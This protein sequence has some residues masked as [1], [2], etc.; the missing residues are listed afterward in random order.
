MASWL[1][2][3][4]GS[5][6]DCDPFEPRPSISMKEI[7]L[8]A[9]MVY[10]F[11]QTLFTDRGNPTPIPPKMRPLLGIRM[12][13]RAHL[14]TCR[15]GCSKHN[16]RLNARLHSLWTRQVGCLPFQ[17]NFSLRFRLQ[18]HRAAWQRHTTRFYLQSTV[19]EPQGRG[20][21][22]AQTVRGCSLAK[23]VLIEA[24]AR[25]R[26]FRMRQPL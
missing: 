9:A 11:T 13:A 21:A 5:K 20:Q 25:A 26:R 10:N 19:G 23:Q 7:S 6:W 15:H 3:Y 24:G 4:K 18:L 12:L 8:R 17:P 22:Y 14:S 1:C 16:L 2:Y